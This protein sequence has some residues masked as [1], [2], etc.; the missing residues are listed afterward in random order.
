MSEIEQENPR[1]AQY[2]KGFKVKRNSLFHAKYYA[3]QAFEDNGGP[4]DHL[5]SKKQAMSL[6]KTTAVAA[7]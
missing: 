4:I 6:L 2:V 5:L 3:L 7:K 1:F